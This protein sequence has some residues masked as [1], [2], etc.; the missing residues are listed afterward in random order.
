MKILYGFYRADSGEILHKGQ[1]VQIHSPHDARLI[2]IGMVFQDFTLIPALTVAE[3][4]A[5]FLPH[6][7]VLLNT[8]A[9]NRRIQEVSERYD[10]RVNPQAMVSALDWIAN[11]IGTEELDRALLEFSID[12]PPL[13]V[14]RRQTTAQEYLKD[15]T[16]GIPN[17][18]LLLEEMA[19]QELE[20]YGEDSRLLR[21]L[22]ELP[23]SV[24]QK[25]KTLLLS[26]P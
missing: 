8:K 9:I 11:H 10:F 2:Q 5:L 18:A 6:L 4:L 16:E 25:H 21:C 13:A 26:L 19:L 20:Q 24:V 14:Y 3:N 23:E 17:R 12:F 22:Q 15:T 1:P 7:P